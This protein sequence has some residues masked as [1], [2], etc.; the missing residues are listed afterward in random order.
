VRL[1]RINDATHILKRCQLSGAPNLT[2]LFSLIEKEMPSFESHSGP[3][4]K[5]LIIRNS[6]TL[7]DG[8]Y[9]LNL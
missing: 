6:L 3:I 8:S 7:S 5:S 9:E 2:N 4:D 1:V